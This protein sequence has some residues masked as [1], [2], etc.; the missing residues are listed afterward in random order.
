MWEE[1]LQHQSQL[2]TQGPDWLQNLRKEGLQQFETLGLP[3]AKNEAWKYTSVKGLSAIP[4]SQGK[5]YQ[6]APNSP[7]ELACVRWQKQSS[8]KITL[9]NGQFAPSLSHLSGLPAGIEVLS[10]K[11][12]ITQKPNQVQKYLNQQTSSEN[13]PFVA[14]NTALLEDGVW[15][16]IDT[17]VILDQPLEIL[18]LSLANGAP[19]ASQ[20]RSIIIAGPQA[21]LTLI[22]TFAGKRGAHPY[23]TNGV[24]EI[25]AQTGAVLQHYKVQDE[26]EQSFHV[27]SLGIKQAKDSQVS[28]THLSI[29]AAL[30][31][32]ETYS[33]L[34]EAGAHCTLNGLSLA[35]GTQHVDH[36]TKMLHHSPHCTSQ[37]LYKN[38]LDEKSHGVFN[39]QI[40]VKPDAQKTSSTLTNNNL[41]LSKEAVIDT[42]PLLEIFADDVKCA[43]GATIGRLDENQIF[44]LRSRGIS[45]EHARHLLTYAFASEIVHQVKVDSLRAEL[46]KILLNRLHIAELSVEGGTVL[47]SLAQEIPGA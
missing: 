31:R 36:Q 4:F 44:Y 42:K 7:D 33:D 34:N 32:Y 13:E 17:G 3:T 1:L 46:E 25:F 19:S 15:V 28:S 18:Y 40:F 29:G 26:C 30:S 12:A 6:V 21:Q 23:L 5:A 2:A 41:L 35:H 8:H 24:T 27:S 38:I 43:H 11:E 10:L 39:G 37:E 22:E 14:L 20:P 9:V 16:A 45:Q 47:K